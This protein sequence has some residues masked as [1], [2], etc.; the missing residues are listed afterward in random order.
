MGGLYD[1]G[2]I[3]QE[4]RRLNQ[5]IQQRH[6][7]LCNF[8]KDLSDEEIEDLSQY[9][10]N[11]LRCHNSGE[12][13]K[14]PTLEKTKAFLLLFSEAAADD[15]ANRILSYLESREFGWH[16]DEYYLSNSCLLRCLHSPEGH[17]KKSAKLD[18]PE[19]AENVLSDIW[20][21]FFD[22]ENEISP[23]TLFLFSYCLASLFSSILNR[24]GISPPFILQ[25]ACDRAS[26][27][28]Q[29]IIDIIEICDVNSGLHK[30]CNKNEYDYRCC[31]Y[32]SQIYYPTQSAAKDIDE[33]IHNYTDSPVLVLGYENER[34]YNALLREV[35]NIP[36]KKRALDLK[37]RFNVLPVFVCPM[38]K[39]NFDNVFN[40][41]LSDF[42]I[43]GEYLRLIRD[44]K[45]MLASWVLDLVMEM[46]KHTIR[47]IRKGTVR[48]SS[49]TRSVLLH[50]IG[51]YMN[52][53]S[54]RYPALTVKNSQ[55]IGF[56]NF[57]FK[58][59]LGVFL[60]L[61]TFDAAEK[62]EYVQKNGKPL[63]QSKNEAINWLSD[64][65]EKNLAQLH[66]RYLPTPIGS[67]IKN[68]DAVRLAKQIEKHFRALK[69]HIRV[70]PTDTKEDRYIFNVDT[71]YETK[72]AEIS[73]NADTV[74]RRLKEYEYF[75]T[76]LSDRTK[77]RLIVA[78][79]SLQD[80]SLI[81][82]LRSEK[83]SESKMI[84]PYA[85]GY[86]DTGEMCVEDLKEFPHLLL[87]GATNSGKSVA[88]ISLLTSIAYR[89][90]TGDVNVLIL[91]LLGVEESD[92]NLFDDQP[93]LSSTVITDPIAGANAIL[94]LYEESKRRAKNKN[95][96]E[97]P[98][99]VCVIDEFPRLFSNTQNKEYNNHIENAISDLLST[100]RHQKIHFVL[101]AQNPVKEYMKKSN[102][103]NITNRIALKCA[104][105]QNSNAILGRSGAEKLIGQ[106]QMIFDSRL[107]LDKRLQGSYI[108]KSD[109][110]KLLGE[111]RKTFVQHNKYPFRLGELK[112]NHFSIESDSESSMLM[113]KTRF[114]SEDDNLLESILWIL[115]QKQ[116]ANYKLQKHLHIG[117]NVAVRLLERLEKLALIHRLNG[118]LG[119]E[120]L[121][122]CFE[123]L[124][125]QVIDF[126]KRKG[127]NETSIR[128][129]F[130][131]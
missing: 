96:D 117:N 17:C 76:D 71:L 90:R 12:L 130:G 126:L 72:I 107:E 7:L 58:K 48:L 85:I 80:N 100:G 45:Q 60:R 121:P 75:R 2:H 44:N 78:K 128:D 79:K 86:D 59:Y 124:P 74:Q 46:D 88:M 105:Y 94:S 36:T 66:R 33:L 18:Y 106:G 92:F 19:L 110:R 42:D 61:C 28:Y 97:L 24:D 83:F 82:I 70:V 81:E 21:I 101:A 111:I 29:L 115:P 102:I 54:Q 84:I 118:N 35:V 116:I 63:Q 108:G 109:A 39:E 122:K 3:E 103:A 22:E 34:Y 14:K 15:D 57:F 123:D 87:G 53:T 91:D 20:G 6:E 93:F 120:V 23:I 55:N 64:L 31:G 56:L 5:T 16:N 49:N 8:L 51:L 9:V 62:I 125:D 114:R 119:W 10:L 37:D 65:S 1:A 112:P 73:K 32:K 131:A 30:D 47:P 104:H 4:R 113:P 38:I 77:I 13:S 129:A 67:A 95:L 69:V 98:Y 27:L 26:A 52:Q 11:F 43:D 127:V 50:D 25:I 89:H 41:D 68:K 99:I 40:I